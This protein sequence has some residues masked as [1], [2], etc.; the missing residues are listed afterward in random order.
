MR[1]STLIKQLFTRL[2]YKVRVNTGTGKG[3]WI[4]AWIPCRRGRMTLQYDQP[5]FPLD[6][7]IACLKIVYPNSPTC[8]SGNA[9]NVRNY[10]IAMVE[11]EWITFLNT[12]TPPQPSS[13]MARIMAVVP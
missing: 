4:C 13:T 9:G 5:E 7:R 11:S 6:L 2:G 3:R 10:M 12:Y 8:W 1:N